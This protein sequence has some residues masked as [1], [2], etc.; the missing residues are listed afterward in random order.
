MKAFTSDEFT[1]NLSRVTNL[2]STYLAAQSG[3]G[4]GRRNAHSSDTLRAAVVFLHSALEE[5]IRNIFL[6][7]LP[8]GPAENLDS[9]PLKTSP[10]RHK[11]FTLGDLKQYDGLFVH[12]VIRES[13]N[14]HA[15]RMSINNPA[16]LRSALKLAE[17]D[18][19]SLDE[20]FSE[21]GRIM[22]RRHQIVHQMDR[23]HEKGRGN[24]RV[25]T[26]SVAQVSGWRDR[27]REFGHALIELAF[28]GE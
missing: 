2:I 4:Q 16:D 18:T 11:G 7:R 1:Q 12:N 5:L 9:I 8:R 26:I 25:Q 21:L 22:S 14:A 20:H 13:I 17:I 15:D 10:A 24:A 3:R 27:V 28:Q 23:N 19:T 6:D